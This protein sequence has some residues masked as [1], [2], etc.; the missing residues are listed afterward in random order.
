MPV[1]TTAVTRFSTG[2]AIWNRL[3]GDYSNKEA[4]SPPTG[5]VMSSLAAPG[6]L[7]SKGGIAGKGGGL[8]G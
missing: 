1:Q 5:R 8:A 6:G 7:A 4:G 2:G 3:G